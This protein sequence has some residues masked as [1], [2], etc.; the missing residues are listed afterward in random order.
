MCMSSQQP[1]PRPGATSDQVRDYYQT[2][3]GRD[4]SDEEVTYWEGNPDAES[5]ISNSE[6]ATAYRKVWSDRAKAPTTVTAPQYSN[7]AAHEKPAGNALQAG[8][9][10][11]Q[12]TNYGE[13]YYRLINNPML[14][15]LGSV[16]RG[17]A[18]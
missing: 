8:E 1:T 14:A 17:A 15:K 2:H 9:T 13:Q 3:T 18:A 5:S 7:V 4:A 16:G 6:E 11:S 12:R 10:Q